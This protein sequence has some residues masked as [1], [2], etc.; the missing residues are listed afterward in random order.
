VVPRLQKL[1]RDLDHIESDLVQILNEPAKFV[2]VR[3]KE[4][5]RWQKLKQTIRV[6]LPH[7]RQAERLPAR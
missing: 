7:T 4:E 2:S 3:E 6:E 5:R 1:L